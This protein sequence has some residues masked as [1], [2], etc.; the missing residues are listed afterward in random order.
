M[1]LWDRT[2]AWNVLPKIA[3]GHFEEHPA[4]YFNRDTPFYFG[5]Q[6]K[7]YGSFSGCPLVVPYTSSRGTIDKKLIDGSGFQNWKSRP[8]NL[9]I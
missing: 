7:K 3:F 9:G 2:F 1:T 8:I 6:K 5:L 4:P